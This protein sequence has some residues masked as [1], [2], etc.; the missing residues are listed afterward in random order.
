MTETATS[1]YQSAVRW[2]VQRIRVGWLPLIASCGLWWLA[3]TIHPTGHYPWLYRVT[4]IASAILATLQL[5][6][7]L[8]FGKRLN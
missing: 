5:A 4:T 3:F 7:T 8:R 6:Y 2:L 1:K